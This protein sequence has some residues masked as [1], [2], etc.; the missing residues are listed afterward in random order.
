MC[1]ASVSSQESVHK[2]SFNAGAITLISE[3]RGDGKSSG[4]TTFVVMSAFEWR[5]Y[6]APYH[7]LYYALHGRRELLFGRP[8]TE[9]VIVQKLP[10]YVHSCLG[11][12]TADQ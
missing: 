5:L 2:V 3:G 1:E 9:G 4:K 7:L 6:S 12:H 10:S 8:K 11:G